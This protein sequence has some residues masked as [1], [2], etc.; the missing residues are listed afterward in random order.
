MLDDAFPLVL[1][2]APL[3][4]GPDERTTL[5]RKAFSAVVQHSSAKEIVIAL[6]MRFSQLT[7]TNADSDDEDHSAGASDGQDGATG[8]A[9][10][11]GAPQELAHLVGFYAT[12]QSD[13]GPDPLSMRVR[14]QQSADG[15]LL[16]GDWL[17]SA[18]SSSRKAAGRVPPHR[19]RL[20]HKRDRQPRSRGHVPPLSRIRNR[21][22]AV[23]ALAG[24][25]AQR[26]RRLRTGRAPERAGGGRGRRGQSCIAIPILSLGLAPLPLSY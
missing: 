7:P 17:F 22:R 16:L 14:C 9:G 24:A 4:R 21:H 20:H 12:G 2:L 11:A 23:H 26:S 5:A 25:S 8:E 10:L 3:L 13:V 18:G 19:R 15:S 1:E 6:D